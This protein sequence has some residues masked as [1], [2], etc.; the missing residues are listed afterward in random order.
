MAR[1][2]ENQVFVFAAN[3]CGHDGKYQYPGNSM[4][5]SPLGDILLETGNEEGAYVADINFGDLAKSRELVDVLSARLN[6]IDEI[7]NGQL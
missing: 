5:I 1:A 6:I 7:D 4:I 3:C 2:V